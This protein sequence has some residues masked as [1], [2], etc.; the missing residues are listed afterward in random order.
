MDVKTK[1]IDID[2]KALKAAG[3]D[4]ASLGEGLAAEFTAIVTTN[5]EDRD[6][7]I[8]EPAGATLDT[9]MPL[10][11]QH[12]PNQPIG[13]YLATV[14]HDS[15]KVVAKFGVADTAQGRDVVKLLELG[16]LRLSH[17]FRALD[18]EQRK[19]AKGYHFKRFEVIEASLVSIPANP[20]AQV[21]ALATKSFESQPIK[22]W[23]ENI[24]TKAM[25][26]L[27]TPPVETKANTLTADEIKAAVRDGMKEA[28][29]LLTAAPAGGDGASTGQ[30]STGQKSTGQ[31]STGP[32][33]AD[34]LLAGSSKNV[35]VKGVADRYGR[36]TRKLKHLKTGESVYHVGG[37]EPESMS[38][39]NSAKA[40]AFLKQL[41]K[42]AGIPVVLREEERAA[43]DLCF[44]E[45]WIGDYNG[46][47]SEEIDGTRMKALLDDGI[48]GG[49][50]AVPYWF[51]ADLITFPLLVGELYPFVDIR[52]VPRGA[53]VHGASVANPTV[54]WGPSEGSEMP[55]FDTSSFVAA[56]NTS[57]F[58]VTCAIEVGRDE[59]AD[60]PADLGR[61]I[62]ENVG[63]RLASELDKV[64]AIGNG[65]SQPTG[66]FTASGLNSFNADN[67]TSG[68]PTVNDYMSM[69][70]GIQKQYRTAA[71]RPAFISNDVSYQRSRQIRVD[72]H[73]LT[74]GGTTTINQLPVMSPLNDVANY[75]TLATPHR[76]SQ[77]IGNSDICYGALSRY[78]MYRRLGFEIRWVT[79]G[80]E[81][82]RRNTVMLV[83]R[84]RFGGQPVDGNAF[85]VCTD[86][87][88]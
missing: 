72:P 81:L 22:A 19:G 35:N 21:L 59:L 79:E 4:G 36:E 11:W 58:P 77:S 8:L 3:T 25:S 62:T 38:Q 42:K 66:I 44:G 65:T 2:A 1:T 45:K 51:D 83:V 56:I 69:M 84:G 86:A 24:R 87:Q 39:L 88:S 41:A 33:P 37:A 85:C 64:V 74:G 12:D 57:I 18:F 55:L 6:Y 73:S 31:K 7:D 29:T 52:N 32:T 9:K 46:Q 26:T 5:K 75:S 76:I 27:T 60:S 63:Q 71:M 50:A 54:T 40:M 47:Y 68:P 34:L 49:S 43:L 17:G 48:S 30:K 16:V 15:E 53:S 28:I 80:A 14:E 70:F 61:T 20:D 82:A 10:L 78:R 67:T 23:V 13:K